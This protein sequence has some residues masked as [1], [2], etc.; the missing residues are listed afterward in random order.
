MKRSCLWISGVILP[1]TMLA[2]G[3]AN[4]Q[5]YKCT[6]YDSLNNKEITIYTDAPCGE[7]LKQ[8]VINVPVKTYTTASPNQSSLD[9]KVA[10]AVLDQ[11][12]ALARALA[13]SKEHWRLITM[14]EG[15]QL[16]VKTAPIVANQMNTQN[17]CAA[18]RNA[19]ELAAGARWPDEEL[20]AI[21]KISMYAAC[22]VSDPLDQNSVVVVGNRFGGI[23]PSRWVG[24]PYGPIVYNRPHFNKH[25]PHRINR[26]GLSINY[27]NKR[28]GVRAQ[29]GGLQTQTDIRQQFRTKNFA[30][31]Q[32]S[33]IRQQ[34]R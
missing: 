6:S 28:F 27:Q 10:Q 23:Q 30:A 34:F 21:K 25:P 19:Y 12:F 3:H 17:E 2:A 8:T 32:Q 29:T 11:D 4:A 22:G 33:D 5:V 15:K 7:Q 18:A 16:T 13:T 24:L 26:G 9:L 31:Q 14:A 20:I 1:V